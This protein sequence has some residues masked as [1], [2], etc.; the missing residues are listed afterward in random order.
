MPIID[1]SEYYL[2]K[3]NK[4][5]HASCFPNNI[6]A[7]ISGATGSGKTNLILNFLLN[8]GMF[9][10]SDVYIQDIY[11]SQKALEIYKQKIL[12]LQGGKQFIK[13]S[14]EGRKLLRLKQGR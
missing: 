14:G 1:Y 5:N 7:V 4:K 3:S 6:F 9:D 13:K 11:V 8:D 2:N 10:Y 12:G